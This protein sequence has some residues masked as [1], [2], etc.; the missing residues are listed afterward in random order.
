MSTAK[1]E[2]SFSVGK[3][4]FGEHSLNGSSTAESMRLDL[5]CAKGEP[6]HVKDADAKRAQDSK[7]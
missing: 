6:K 7:T 5:A 3:R 1:L 2:Q 4:A